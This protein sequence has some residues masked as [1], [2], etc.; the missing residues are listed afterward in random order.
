MNSPIMYETSS[1]PHNKVNIVTNLSA[2]FVGVKS[3]KPTVVNDVQAKYTI[4]IV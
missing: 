2:L 3:P 4:N 1:T